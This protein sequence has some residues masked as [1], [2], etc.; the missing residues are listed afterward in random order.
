MDPQL[1]ELHIKHEL[2]QSSLEPELQ[3]TKFTDEDSPHSSSDEKNNSHGHPGPINNCVTVTAG[4]ENLN[5]FD[6]TKFICDICGQH[7]RT[8]RYMGSH[9]IKHKREIMGISQA[10]G[11]QCAIKGCEKSFEKKSLLNRHQKKMHQINP[12]PLQKKQKLSCHLCPKKFVMQ[13][14]LDGHIREVH[15]GLKA[16]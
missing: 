12:E 6:T 14:K 1:D 15:E 7:F 13:F 5:P 16:S 4:S 2:H 8:K 3:V 9:M 10:I 11:F